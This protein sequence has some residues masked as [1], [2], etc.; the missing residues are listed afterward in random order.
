MPV[1]LVDRTALSLGSPRRIGIASRFLHDHSIGRLMLGLLAHLHAREDCLIYLFHAVT[2][3]DDALRCEIE[4]LVDSSIVLP[5]ALQAAREAISETRLDVLFYPDIGM[6]PVTY[7]LA[8][9]RLA[10]V[11]CA[12]W[13]HPVT[14]GMPTIDYFLSCDAAEPE[15][16]E[17]HYSEIL[18]R[19]GGLPFSYR[20]PSRPNPLGSRA[21]FDLPTEATIYFLA[22]NLSKIHPDMDASLAEILRGDPTGVILLLEGQDIKWG[23]ILRGRFAETL[24]PNAERV[25]FRSRQSHENYMRLLALSDVSLDSFPFC[26]GN[27][28]Y[29][30]LAMGT[31]MV[32]LPGDYLH[33]RLSLAIYR[34]M[35]MLD[36]VV[37]DPGDFARIALR[38]GTEPE[39]RQTIEK[40]IESSSDNIFDDPIF[41]CDARDSLLTVEPRPA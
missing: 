13:G 23:Q 8:Q 15:G 31:P 9:A 28:T 2:P 35:E 32:T 40:Q 14:T 19:L 26:G 20:R 41:L 3:Q 37:K 18:V 1:S 39:F 30:S 7:F 10:P 21:D 27:T 11:R 33:G 16:A 5:G 24:G 36:C 12:T 4:A 38:L 34:H 17:T 25:V 29:Q 6:D 22:Q